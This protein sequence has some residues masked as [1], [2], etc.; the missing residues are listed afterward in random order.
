MGNRYNSITSAGTT[1]PSVKSR[2]TFNETP[3]LGGHKIVSML[4]SELVRNNIVTRQNL[5]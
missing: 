3:V 5:V 4:K 1:Y 2:S